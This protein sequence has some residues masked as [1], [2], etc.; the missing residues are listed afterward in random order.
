MVKI[1][2]IGA[3]VAGLSAAWHLA[4]SQGSVVPVLFEAQRRFG[5]HANTVDVSLPDHQGRVVTHGVDTGFLVCNQRTY[6]G[7]IGLFKDLGVET[8]ASEMSFSVQAPGLAGSGSKL[9]WSGSSLG[10]VFSQRR[11]LASPRFLGMLAQILKFNRLATAMARDPAQAEAMAHETVADFLDRHRFGRAF[12]EGYLLPMVA[13][14]WSCPVEQMLAFPV[15]TLLRF[16]DNHGLLQVVDRPPWFTVRGGSRCYVDA[17]I[18]RLPQ[19]Y[20][21][22]PV[23][24]VER[25]EAGVVVHSSRG[26]ERFNA[27]VMACHAPQALALLSVQATRDERAVLAAMRTQP[28]RAVLHTDASVMPRARRAWAAWNFERREV[29]DASRPVC[30]HYWINRLQPLPFARDVFV[31]LNPL[32]EPAASKVIGSYDYA[33]PVFD[34]DALRAQNRLA[35]IQGRHHTWY[36]GAWCGYGFHEDGFQAGRSAAAAILP[37]MVGR[38][39]VKEAA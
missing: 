2:I 11:N 32:R 17:I 30:L 14:I 21:G 19:A 1:A 33:H 15:A 25:D 36:A 16:C 27:V 9:E 20:A 39:R 28:N 34:V 24:R 31:S 37:S 26:P 6:P 8:A 5:G 18:A 13:C 23:H 3:G 22:T 38:E 29:L 4:Q 35:R 7:L 12:R 10:S